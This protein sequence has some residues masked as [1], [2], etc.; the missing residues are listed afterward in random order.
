[1]KSQN[2]ND[3]ITESFQ[4]IVCRKPTEK[5]IKLLTEYYQDEVGMFSKNKKEAHKV[6]NVGEHPHEEKVAEDQAAAL[7]RVINTLYNMEETIVKS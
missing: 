6:L 5:E 7:M 2:V 1:L 3:R 4:R